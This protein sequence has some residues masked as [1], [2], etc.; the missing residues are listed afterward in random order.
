MK[1]TRVP[2]C[3]HNPGPGQLSISDSCE[4]LLISARTH[5]LWPAFERVSLVRFVCERAGAFRAETI[6]RSPDHQFV[7]TQ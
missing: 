4:L 5:S 2:P 6:I 1:H 3:A 7:F